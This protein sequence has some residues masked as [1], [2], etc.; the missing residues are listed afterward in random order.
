MS[1]RIRIHHRIIATVDIQII[2]LHISVC[3]EVGK[4]IRTNKPS[5]VGVIQPR[6]CAIEAEAVVG[7]A[8]RSVLPFSVKMPSVKN[9]YSV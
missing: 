1:T 8:V 9:A 4:T 2:T 3:T 7:V 5:A 6:L